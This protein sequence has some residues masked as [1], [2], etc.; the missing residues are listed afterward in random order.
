MQKVRGWAKFV[1]AQLHYSL[2]DRDIEHDLAPF[3][4][5]GG[6]GM[7]VWSPLGVGS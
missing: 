7:L 6:L 4:R 1:S 2:I 3:L 5:A